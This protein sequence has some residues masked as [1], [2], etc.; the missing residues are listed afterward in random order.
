MEAR[1]WDS[2]DQRGYRESQEGGKVTERKEVGDV[3]WQLGGSY[4]QQPVYIGEDDTG[5]LERSLLD[6]GLVA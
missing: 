1:N 3:G 6:K 5:I 4:G 2:E